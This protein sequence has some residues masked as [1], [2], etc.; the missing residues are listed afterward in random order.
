M[1][2]IGNVRIRFREFRGTTVAKIGYKTNLI[3]FPELLETN[4]EATGAIFVFIETLD[5]IQFDVVPKLWEPKLQ[6]YIF[7]PNSYVIHSYGSSYYIWSFP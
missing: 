3:C 2:T 6:I 1:L 7:Y 5:T 4:L